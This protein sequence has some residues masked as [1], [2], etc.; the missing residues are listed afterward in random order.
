MELLRT[1]GID[2]GVA[3]PRH[4]LNDSKTAHPRRLAA[5]VRDSVV[6]EQEAMIAV[7][8]EPGEV[9][10]ADWLDGEAG[11]AVLTDSTACRWTLLFL[12]LKTNRNPRDV[13]ANGEYFRH[14]NL[15]VRAFVI[16][17]LLLPC[18]SEPERIRKLFV[19]IHELQVRAA[20]GVIDPTL[21]MPIRVDQARK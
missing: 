5:V 13:A 11:D 15:A 14:A 7:H 3:R 10:N 21:E 6:G 1:C 17:R 19:A 2:H 8:L 20:K 18:R 16:C 4:H 12:P 9:A